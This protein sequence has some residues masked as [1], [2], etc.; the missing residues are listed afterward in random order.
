[1]VRQNGQRGLCYRQSDEGYY[2]GCD[3]RCPIFAQV[4]S[5]L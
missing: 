2:G 5:S 3:E 4:S 1:M